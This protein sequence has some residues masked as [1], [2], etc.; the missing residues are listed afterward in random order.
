VVRATKTV[1]FEGKSNDF[2][3][4]VRGTKVALLRGNRASQAQTAPQPLQ[5]LILYPGR[6]FK[7]ARGLPSAAFEFRL[8]R[9]GVDERRVTRLR[10]RMRGGWRFERGIRRGAGV[11]ERRGDR[12]RR[13]AGRGVL[14]SGRGSLRRSQI[15]SRA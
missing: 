14:Q 10:R 7:S 9:I 6:T 12:D 8:F 15:V 1:D 13:A 2:V 3:V 11:G 5:L 4:F